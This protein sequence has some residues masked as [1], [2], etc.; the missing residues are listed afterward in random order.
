MFEETDA[1]K[2]IYQIELLE[3]SPQNPESEIYLRFLEES[4]VEVAATYMR[5]AFLCKR[6]ADGPFAIYSD[7]DTKIRY[8]NRLKNFWT[9]IIAL[10]L[11]AGLL[12]FVIGFVNFFS[13]ERQEYRAWSWQN[14]VAG[15]LCTGIGIV[16]IFTL[17][18]PVYLQIRKLK[19]E[20]RLYD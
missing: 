18:R 5:W 2:Y 3:K 7:Y 1:G 11:T 16:F 14:L 10:E 9:A 20:K 17:L 6:A 8:L 15:A 19:K 4:G 12:N 13:N